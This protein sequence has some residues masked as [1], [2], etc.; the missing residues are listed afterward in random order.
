MFFCRSL[1]QNGGSYRNQTILRVVFFVDMPAGSRYRWELPVFD[2]RVARGR[3]RCP[4]FLPGQA[5]AIS[6]HLT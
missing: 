3:W 6:Y 4:V 1:A 5:K 2:G